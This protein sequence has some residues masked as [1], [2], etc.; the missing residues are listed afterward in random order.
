MNRTDALLARREAVVPRGVGRLNRLVVASGRG[1]H[2]VDVEGREYLDL[3]TGIG[4]MGAGHSQPAVIEA[5]VAQLQALQHACFHVATYEPYVALC[6]KLVGLVPHGAASKALLVNTGAEAV[7][8]AIKIARQA[9]ARPAVLCFT[10]AFHGRTLMGM[11]LTS[12]VSYKAGCGPFAPEVYRL[13]YPNRW[14]YGEGLSE[15]IFVARELDRLRDA[16][17]S[18]VPAEQIAAIVL[19]VVQGE[20]GF[21][22]C[23]FGW[24]RGLRE[25]CDRHGILLVIDEVQTGLCR[26]GRWAAHH[27]TG[28]LPDISTW[29]KALGGGLPIAAVVGRAAVMDRALPGTLGGTYG[30]NPVACASAL[31]TLDLMERERFDL[32]ALRIGERIRERLLALQARCPL[33]AEVRGLGAMQAFELCE[34]GDPRRPATDAATRAID[35]CI[36]RGVLVI[37]AGAHRNVIRLLP[38]LVISDAELDR[39][40]EVLTDVVANLEGSTR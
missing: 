36:A 31:A 26:T 33:V 30:G 19:E 38:P 17:V 32:R 15:E 1:T 40:L 22:V 25:E 39:A 18:M 20:G 37:A 6:E 4:V 23:P 21:T 7:E 27:H 24:L 35:G 3:A 28:V 5:A 14:R 8:N 13:P 16:F 12:K 2:L 11:T 9:T 10:E 29:A 34:Q